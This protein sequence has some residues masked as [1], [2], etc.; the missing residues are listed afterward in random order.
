VYLANLRHS[1]HVAV[2]ADRQ[3]H[4]PQSHRASGVHYQLSSSV[5]RPL[6]NHEPA[7]GNALLH[8][9]EWEEDSTRPI[10]TDWQQGGDGVGDSACF[11][12]ALDTAGNGGRMSAN[13]IVNPWVFTAAA[14]C[15]RVDGL[16]ARRR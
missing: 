15:R 1:G 7:V 6:G 2:D 8:T 4:Q 11:A 3:L 9:R 12:S 14:P 10:D 13:W 16:A 5:T